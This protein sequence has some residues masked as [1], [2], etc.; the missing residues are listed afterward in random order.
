M[1]LKYNEWWLTYCSS[2]VVVG[3]GSTYT[4]LNIFPNI[5]VV[6]KTKI[7][8]KAVVESNPLQITNFVLVVGTIFK[9]DD[10]NIDAI[11]INKNFRFFL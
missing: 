8:L 2:F 11:R 3:N 7:R 5:C 6:I 9:M 10:K 1:Q 4:V